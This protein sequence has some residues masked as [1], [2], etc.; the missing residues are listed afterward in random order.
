MARHL[1]RARRSYAVRREVVLR[2][3]AGDLGRLGRVLPSAAGLHVAFELH[4]GV[5][6]AE[7]VDRAVAAGVQ[8]DRLSQYAVS[9]DPRRGFGISYGTV[10]EGPLDE[11]LTLLAGR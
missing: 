10:A 3:G 4:D 1:H 5:D 7:V 11:A 9:A 6:E 2:H 8:L